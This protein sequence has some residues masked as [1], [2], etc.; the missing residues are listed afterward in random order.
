MSQEAIVPMIAA[1][2]AA[3]AIVDAIDESAHL[4]KFAKAKA[5][6]RKE[7]KRVA[8]KKQ[9]AK[10]SKT[11]AVKPKATTE[12]KKRTKKKKQSSFKLY[13][14]RLKN[15]I[16]SEFRMRGNSVRIM[17]SLIQHTISTLMKDANGCVTRSKRA[18]LSELDVRTACCMSFP[19]ELA[20]HAATYGNNAIVSTM[21]KSVKSES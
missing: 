12:K 10:T 3:V 17:D 9:E 20:L 13:T 16:N 5:A 4:T 11:S 15:T 8:Q 18:T 21:K 7:K 1:A 6:D 2:T 14:L 19:G